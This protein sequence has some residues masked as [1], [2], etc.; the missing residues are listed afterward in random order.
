MPILNYTTSIPS[1]KTIGE[2]QK[3]LG[4]SG[5]TKITID[6]TDKI[7]SSITFCLLLNGNTVG[8][9]LPA[10][11]SGVLKAYAKQQKSA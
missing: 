7:P 4:D 2:I 10:N 3:I 11:C 9:A 6:Y 5:A 1:E 8:F